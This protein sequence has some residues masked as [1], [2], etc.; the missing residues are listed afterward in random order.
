MT[1]NPTQKILFTSPSSSGIPGSPFLI[2][3]IWLIHDTPLQDDHLLEW[4]WFEQGRMR[5]PSF[6]RIG[7]SVSVRFIT[8]D[9]FIVFT[10]GYLV[11]LQYIQC[12]ILQKVKIFKYKYNIYS[13]DI[14]NHISTSYLKLRSIPHT[15][16]HTT[17]SMYMVFFK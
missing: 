13:K 16:P 3:R 6:G 8:I 17:L 14:E 15:I 4:Q 1:H 2:C 10:Y 5:S 7:C 12:I 11:P 9:G